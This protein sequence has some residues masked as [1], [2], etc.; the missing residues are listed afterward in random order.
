MCKYMCS[1]SD[2]AFSPICH[3][4]Y[5]YCNGYNTG[6]IEEQGGKPRATIQEALLNTAE[7]AKAARKPRVQH[8]YIRGTQ[9]N[10][11][12]TIQK[13]VWRDGINS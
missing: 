10:R 1:P 3:Y 11:C 8:G 4:P 6:L 5:R 7:T 9:V 12:T 13:N 2:V